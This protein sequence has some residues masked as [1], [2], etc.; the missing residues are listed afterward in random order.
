MKL[1]N[2]K[3]SKMAATAKV[4]EAK[5]RNKNNRLSNRE[6]P[7]NDRIHKCRL[8]IIKSFPL[9]RR[10]SPTPN[11]LLHFLEPQHSSTLVSSYKKLSETTLSSFFNLAFHGILIFDT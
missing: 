11:F 9:K 10:E 7:I 3:K 5:S 8:K 1:K 4:E 6:Y 2:K